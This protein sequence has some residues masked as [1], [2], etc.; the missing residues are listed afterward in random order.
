MS[1]AALFHHICLRGSPWAGASPRLLFSV[2]ENTVP[3]PFW[4]PCG[5]HHFQTST[6]RLT[7]SKDGQDALLT[8]QSQGTCRLTCDF[9]SELFPR[10]LTPEV[11]FP[12]RRKLHTQAEVPRTGGSSTH[13]EA[14]VTHSGGS[15]AIQVEISP[16]R[17]KSDSTCDARASS[18]STRENQD[19]TNE[20]NSQA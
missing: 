20:H 5:R 14:E 7:E 13:S 8:P 9:R 4:L 3:S 12:V 18:C 15:S 10:W 17:W 6:P 11:P 2:A 19:I 16:H 1:R